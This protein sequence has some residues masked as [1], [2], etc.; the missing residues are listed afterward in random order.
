MLST[1]NTVGITF[2]RLEQGMEDLNIRMIPF[3]IIF[4]QTVFFIILR[5][6]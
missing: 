3:F 1:Q 2:V 4:D 5:R 6:Q